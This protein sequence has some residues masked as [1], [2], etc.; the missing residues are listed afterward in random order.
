M[1]RATALF[2][3]MLISAM[4]IFA[5]A[6]VI[7][8]SMAKETAD[9]FLSLDNEWHNTTDAKVQLVEQNGTPAYYIVE[10][11]AGGWAIVSAQSSSSPVIGYNTTGKF[12]A[13]APVNELL[14]FNAKLITARAKELGTVEHVGWQRVKQRKA[15]AEKNTTPDIAPLI[16]INLNQSYPFNTYCP[17]IDGKNTLVGCVAVGMTQAIMVQGY[18]QRPSG[19][20][21]YTCE[22]TGKHSINYDAQPAYDWNAINNCETTGNYDE[23]ARL[24]YHAGVSVD[25]Q[26][27]LEA[28]GTQTDLV[29]EALI[30]NFGYDKKIVYTTARHPDNNKWLELIINELAHGRVVVY[31]GTGEEG[32]HCWNIDGWKQSTQMVHCNWG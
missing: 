24:L 3:V 2:T 7:T 11:T 32:G 15:V 23:V 28:S 13:P 14:D 4:S 1:K 19:S 30:R 18:P 12:A 27:G 16:T 6:E 9:S 22:N 26:Y 5:S 20:Y 8:S 29:A 10:Y 25:M 21:S 31:G 17:K